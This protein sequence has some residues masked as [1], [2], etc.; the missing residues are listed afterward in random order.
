[1]SA[2]ADTQSVCGRHGRG[3]ARG[4]Q[5]Q[6]EKQL[7]LRQGI[8]RQETFRSGENKKKEQGSN[9][10]EFCDASGGTF[11]FSCARQIFRG[12]TGACSHG[13]GSCASGA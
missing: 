3:S 7:Y 8:R 10:P 5:E 4:V 9:F 12:E 2:H 1:M 6:R 13:G 11:V